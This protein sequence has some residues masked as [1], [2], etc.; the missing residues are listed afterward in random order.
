M[1]ALTFRFLEDGG[2]PASD[3]A[4]TF[5]AFIGAAQRTLDIAIYDFHARDGASATVADAL[6][7]AQARGVAVRVVFNVD[8]NDAP[9]APRPME[10]DP[11]M[12]DG[13]DVPTHG[14]H[15]QGSLMHHKYVVADGERV[16]TGST[17]W[18][19]DAFTREENVIVLADDA[20]LAAAYGA[21]F[22]EL[23]RR[24]RLEGSGSKGATVAM[25]RGVRATPWFLPSPP[26]VAHL[27][28]ERIGEARR[29]LRICSPVVTSGP[30][31][32]TLAEF[33]G[34]TDF[35]LSGAY[36]ATQMDEV[37]RQWRA[38]P[39]N[40]WKVVA[41]QAIAPRLSGKVSTPYRPGS[42]HDY[43]H[44]KFVV[45][46]D[47]VLVGSYNLSRG[48][49]ENAE[50]VLHVVNEEVAVTFST[51]ADR[52]AARYAGAGAPTAASSAAGQTAALGHQPQ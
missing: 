42:V 34:R 29:R 14:V 50:N 20:Q 41:W 22:D 51:F 27:A 26:S 17:N 47:E 5:N 9:S 39:W 7:A 18:T 4:G 15:D 48:G 40:L 1:G 6:E 21:N 36:D 44:A 32:G 19:D 13:L 2:Q 3:V 25:D 23:W 45:A 24:S 11:G 38:V 8:R 10:S 28:A 43:M 46:D 16:L 12:I 52:L 35:D 30:V 31:L 37:M 49:E 33:A